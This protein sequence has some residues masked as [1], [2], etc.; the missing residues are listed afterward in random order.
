MNVSCN[1]QVTQAFQGNVTSDRIDCGDH[2]KHCE[3]FHFRDESFFS[4]YIF[5]K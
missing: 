3:S 1:L 2:V 4:G 5:K